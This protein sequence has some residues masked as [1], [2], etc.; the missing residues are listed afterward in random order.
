V[1]V[2]VRMGGGT[3]L[4]VV[5]GLAM[6][7]AMVST[8]LGCEGIAV[9][10]REHLLIAD[11]AEE[12]ACRL[13]ELFEHPT[14]GEALGSAGRKLMEA[15][16]SWE[17]AVNRLEALYHRVTGDSSR[18]RPDQLRRGVRTG[19]PHARSNRSTRVGEPA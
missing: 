11:D 2:S 18:R 13:I 8:S 1:V 9:S 6:G 17:H 10:D 3:R 16:Y 7:K 15:Q 19:R 4:K 12:F 5:E 14:L